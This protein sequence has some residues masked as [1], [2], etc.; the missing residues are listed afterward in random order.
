[1]RVKRASAHTRLAAGEQRSE[2]RVV[3]VV[4]VANRRVKLA[5]VSIGRRM[6]RARVID[7]LETRA[8]QFRSREELAMFRAPHEPLLLDAL[9]DEA[10]GHDGH[11]DVDD[12]R[13]RTLVRFEWSDD[14]TWDAWAVALPSG[15]TLFCDSDGDE[16]RVLASV[17]RGSQEEADRFFLEL[18]AESRGQ[19]FG[20]ATAG[21]PPDRVRTAITDREF[22]TDFFVELFEGTLAERSIHRMLARAMKMHA[23]QVEGRD[24]KAE[25][26]H[27]LDLVLVTPTPARTRRKK[28][29]RIRD[30]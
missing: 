4:C 24:F 10:L 17:K 19:Y 29:K 14:G 22:L 12:L 26:A 5:V 23:D 30:L 15:L 7:A 11:L 3:G 27:W 16:T 8:K 6:A 9:I 21:G 1:M 13:A 28:I 20:I 18:L 25:V 2:C